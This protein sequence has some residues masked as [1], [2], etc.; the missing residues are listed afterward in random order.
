MPTPPPSSSTIH[1]ATP[2]YFLVLFSP[3][4]LGLSFIL[5]AV[6]LILSGVL[7]ILAFPVW[8][9]VG[10]F[11]IPRDVDPYDPRWGYKWILDRNLGELR[12]W[13]LGK[14][15]GGGAGGKGKGD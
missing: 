11:V 10:P 5:L 15:G 6:V 4:L 14:V 9:V 7:L 12:D 2:Y 3:L 8:L 1:L 13:V